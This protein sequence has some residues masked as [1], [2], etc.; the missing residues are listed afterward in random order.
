MITKRLSVED[1]LQA[2]AEELKKACDSHE[3]EKHVMRAEP[4]IVALLTLIRAEEDP[5][6]YEEEVRECVV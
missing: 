5:D 6:L 4:L 2:A 1:L 3:W